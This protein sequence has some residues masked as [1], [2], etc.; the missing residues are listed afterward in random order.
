M[1][2]LKLNELFQNGMVL[3]Q[4]KKICVWGIA[5]PGSQI[6]VELQGQQ[7]GTAV[8]EDGS[9]EVW[10][11]SLTASDD[12]QMLVTDGRSTI[13][14]RDIAVGEVWLAGGQSN[15][16]FWM[17][18]EK[19]I[20]E[21]RKNCDNPRVRFFDVPEI[22]YEGQREQFDYSRMA[23]WRKAD[24]E[25]IDYF[26]GVAYYFAAKLERELNVPV[27]VI[28]CNWGG[29]TTAVWMRTESVKQVGRAW[30]EDHER[31]KSGKDM[32]LYWEK[33]KT[34][35]E[36][37]T[38]NPFAN[39]FNEQFL[40]TTPLAE[41]LL[42][43]II[44]SVQRG[45]K[46][47]ENQALAPASFPGCLYEHMLKTLEGLVFRGVLW[48]QG[49]SDEPHADLHA[50]MLTRLIEDWRALFHDSALPF[51]TVQLPGYDSWCGYPQLRFRELRK[52]QKAVA[53]AVDQ[54]Y[55]TSISDAG[56]KMDIHPKDKKTPG[57]RLCLLAL[58]KVYGKDILCEAPEPEE[59]KRD[60]NTII[61]HFKNAQGG[62]HLEGENMNALRVE[63]S[64]VYS[65]YLDGESIRLEFAEEPESYLWIRHAV[66]QYY[67]V[68]L[69]NKN[70]I[71]AIPFELRV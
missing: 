35:V 7:K 70:N 25:N 67:T 54:V 24:S 68:N 43:F 48:Y 59:V 11:E 61:I 52:M 29:T 65:V 5:E 6:R 30:L 57:E 55:M 50:I 20:K 16:E 62:L 19:H 26:S 58:G 32:D 14:L 40:P 36:N 46:D 18:Y 12:E 38:G 44:A 41:E 3:Q 66:Q 2:E 60:G 1:M 51:L 34:L 64:K 22:A 42:Q 8:M 10:L 31:A 63:S 39:P 37:D 28:G 23:I 13:Y 27:G 15:M 71:P 9:F 21:V 69:Y 17:R 33:Q 53:D 49:E 56:E 4:G 47:M 45:E